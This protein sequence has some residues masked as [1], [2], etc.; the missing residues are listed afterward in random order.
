MKPNI[1]S[2]EVLSHSGHPVLDG[3]LVGAGSLW[4]GGIG[5]FTR[6]AVPA[7]VNQHPPADHCNDASRQVLFLSV[8]CYIISRGADYVIL[9]SKNR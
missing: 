1:N 6:R 8:M 4:P 9:H 7:T 5:V 3:A 2:V